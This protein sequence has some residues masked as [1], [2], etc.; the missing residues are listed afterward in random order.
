[1]FYLI[2]GENNPI[3]DDEKNKIIAE[4]ESIPFETL[5]NTTS[6]E[7]FIQ[8]ITAC[9]MFTPRKGH[10]IVNPS[11]IKKLSKKDL[12]LFE[13]GLETAQSH[14]LPI[15]IIIKK[16]DKRS[17][18]YKL[19][20]KYNFLEK[21]CP[22][23]K[24]WEGQKVIHWIVNLCKKQNVTI[25]THN[26]QM[27][28][29][30]YGTNIGVIKQEIE[31]CI[32]AILPK[33]TIT[34]EDLLHAS[35]NSVGQYGQLSN[36]IKQGNIPGIIKSM[37]NLV[38]LKEDPHKIINQ[39]I[40]QINQL[41]PIAMAIKQNLSP[42]MCAKKL[43]KHPFFIKKQMEALYKNPIKN[44]FANLIQEFATIDKQIKT[45]KITAKIAIYALSNKLKYQI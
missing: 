12:E 6:L 21:D 40:F 2:T 22:E 10:I 38:K 20:K 19:L 44:K 9:D 8:N 3:I 32:V 25:S 17:A 15:I 26:A 27:L 35:S 37:N 34:K 33:N 45:G 30:A 7:Q 16:V 14:Q 29:D 41:L 11:W 1:M 36:A 23:F 31:K 4:Y 18:N 28:I 43:G 39:S 5:K 13:N 24:D 42:E